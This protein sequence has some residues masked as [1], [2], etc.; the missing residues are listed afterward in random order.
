MAGLPPHPV[1]SSLQASSAPPQV[2][3]AVR[4]RSGP[5][6][7]VLT[8]TRPEQFGVKEYQRSLCPGLWKMPHD[9]ATPGEFVAAEFEKGPFEPT[10]IASGE[11]HSSLLIEG[12]GGVMFS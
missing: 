7:P 11:E 3:Y 9:A 4:I 10:A 12:G 5:L 1:A 6:Q 2:V 8:V